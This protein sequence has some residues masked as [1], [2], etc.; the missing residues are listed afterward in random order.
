MSGGFSLT[1]HDQPEP[2]VHE[3]GGMSKSRGGVDES[4]SLVS[5]SVHH[6]PW[7]LLQPAPWKL[8]VLCCD[9]SVMLC[10][11]GAQGAGALL[12]AGGEYIHHAAATGDGISVVE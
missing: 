11:W 12:R 2:G 1:A 9:S 10:T 8:S 7:G 6:A 4:V 3:S 5:S